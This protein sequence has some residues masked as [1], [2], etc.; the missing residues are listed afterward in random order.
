[1]IYIS[2][3][4][5]KNNKIRGS[6]EELAMNGFQNIELSGGT[7]Y[8]ENFENDLF[9]LKDKYRLNYRCHN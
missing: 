5:V 2:T 6:V 9:E 1:M 7:E 8:Y 4:C 3:S